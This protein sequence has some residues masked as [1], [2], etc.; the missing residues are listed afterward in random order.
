MK[1]RIVIAWYSESFLKEIG[2][3]LERI[4]YEVITFTD[5]GETLNYLRQNAIDAVMMGIVMP[6]LD[7]FEVIGAIVKEA[8]MPFQKIILVVAPNADASTPRMSLIHGVPFAFWEPIRDMKE[9]LPEDF[10][11]NKS[12]IFM[13]TPIRIGGLRTAI[14]HI[15]QFETVFALEERDGAESEPTL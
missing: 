15:L 6:T 11:W 3:Y 9:N 8:V 14:E 12:G 1:A 4:G 2:G 5:G 7:G 13:T 10:D